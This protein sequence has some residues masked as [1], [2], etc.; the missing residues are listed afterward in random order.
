MASVMTKA[1]LS[2]DVHIETARAA[3][4]IELGRLAK[5]EGTQHTPL[6]PLVATE[7][8]VRNATTLIGETNIQEMQARF[9]G[10]DIDAKGFLNQEEVKELVRLTY[11]A[12][13][14]NIT[15]FMKFFHEKSNVVGITK[16]EFKHGL[17]LLYGDF[18][19]VLTASV[20]DANLDNSRLASV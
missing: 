19:F 10:L 9:K 13:E 3:L 18:T 2:D 8:N 4:S 20:I 14:E 12:P 1:N 5:L 17:T 7:E 11:V 16:D 6:S 15:T